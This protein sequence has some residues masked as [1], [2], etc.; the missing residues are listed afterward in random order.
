MTSSAGRSMA[1]AARAT[2]AAVL[3]PAGSPR[4]CPAASRARTSRTSPHARVGDHEDVR[5]GAMSGARRSTVGS[6]RQRPPSRSGRK[7]FG[8]RSRLRGQSRVPP[9]PAMMT[10][11][12]PTIVH[13]DGYHPPDPTGQEADDHERDRGTDDRRGDPGG[14]MPARTRP[15]PAD[16][17]HR[18]LPRGTRR[19]PAA[20]CQPR[21]AARRPRDMW[22]LAQKTYRA[23]RRY[24]LKL[25]RQRPMTAKRLVWRRS[26]PALRRPVFI[27]GA[28]RSGTT[29]L[30]DCIGRIPEI[31]YHHEPPG[32]Q[33]GRPLR[34]RGP[35]E[36]SPVAAGSSASSTAGWCGSSATATFASARRRPP[37]SSSSRSWRGPSRTPSSSTS[38]ATVATPPPRTCTSPGCGPRTPGPASAS[39]AVTCTAPGPSSG[40]SRSGAR[41]SCAQ[42]RPPHGLGLAA[43]HARPACAEG[44][45]ARRRA[46]PRAALRGRSCVSPWTRVSALL[47]FLGISAPR[48]RGTIF[49]T[50]VQRADDSSVGTWRSTFYPSEL[51]EVEAEAGEL[52][53]R[54]GYAD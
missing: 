46:L 26:C 52:L 16:G 28:A 11:Y 47:D 5:A 41:S 10:A 24:Y 50:A 27:I 15:R 14:P 44:T 3:R 21:A 43:L 19:Q 54:L 51:A 31:T 32:H 18:S 25:E 34:L 36:L 29:F 7:G 45:E 2:A 37:T 23:E 6:S 8:R 38:S 39:R 13:E 33:G 9:P 42:R 53:R 17:A 1:C 4:C 12:M 49:L 22:R 30:G 40:W 48:P 20:G 35:L